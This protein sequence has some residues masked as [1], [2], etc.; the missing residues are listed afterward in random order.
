MYLLIY[1][2]Y[3][4][5]LVILLYLLHI[6]VLLL[7]ILWRLNKIQSINQRELESALDA[8]HEYC[9]NMHLSVSTQ[10][11]KVMIFSRGKVRKYQNFMFGGSI[12][13]VTYVYV[14]LGVNFNYNTSFIKAIERHT[15]I[16]R[17][18]RAMLPL[19]P[20]VDVYHYR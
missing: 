1:L 6:C 15:C 9:K 3:I 19:L 20:K 5:T 11:T 4:F 18:K 17:A 8:V 16:L 10:K 14:Y 2:Y 13:N 12:L 7:F